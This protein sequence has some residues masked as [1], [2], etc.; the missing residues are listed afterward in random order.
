M[1]YRG[2]F[3]H[4]SAWPGLAF[5]DLSGGQNPLLRVLGENSQNEDRCKFQYGGLL[6]P[7]RV[8]CGL[9]IWPGLGRDAEVSNPRTWSASKFGTTPEGQDKPQ[10]E[11]TPPPE[12][13]GRWFF[14]APG[15]AV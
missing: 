13:R 7:F 11:G 2:P 1:G 3:G 14:C 12:G 9:R 8:A 4:R 6:G 15:R 10:R 5:H